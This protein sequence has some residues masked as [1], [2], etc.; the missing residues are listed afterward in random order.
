LFSNARRLRLEPRHARTRTRS[1]A[2]T[3][4]VPADLLLLLLLSIEI[5]PSDILPCQVATLILRVNRRRSGHELRTLL[6][7]VRAIIL[8]WH[9]SYCYWVVIHRF[10]DGRN[11]IALL[12]LTHVELKRGAPEQVR[13][14]ASRIVSPLTILR[15]TSELMRR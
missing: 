15:P 13:R 6:V 12:L 1:A 11:R 2:V 5:P 14:V 4:I 10:L 7:S 8:I 3:T 9:F